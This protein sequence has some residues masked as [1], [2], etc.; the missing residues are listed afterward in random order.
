MKD[1]LFFV[2]HCTK[3]FRLKLVLLFIAIGCSSS[4]GMVY[5]Y[6]LSLVIDNIFY[7][8]NFSFIYRVTSIYIGLF[9]VTQVIYAIQHFVW[10]NLM[11]AFLLSVRRLVF[12]RILALKAS[13]LTSFETGDLVF[14]IN[15]D[16]DQIM[17]FIFTNGF[18]FIA[19]LLRVIASVICIA[20]LSNEMAVL[21]L[22][23]APFSAYM[24]F[25]FSEKARMR[26]KSY[27]E[28]YNRVLSWVSEVIY[29]IKE[30]FHLSAS[31]KARVR[32]NEGIHS[33]GKDKFQISMLEVYS[34]RLIAFVNLLSTLLFY[35]G[36]VYLMS[37]DRLTLGALVAILDYYS[38][39]KSLLLTVNKSMMSLGVRIASI[40]RIVR[41]FQLETE[42]SS[43]VAPL[44]ITQGQIC[45]SNV[46]F[47][48]GNLNVVSEVDLLVEPGSKI[49]IVGAN[50]AGKSTLIDLLLRFYEPSN[51]E[52]TID[53]QNICNYSI[54]SLRD[55]IGIVQQFPVMFE[56]TIYHNL[57]VA[58]EGCSEEALISAAKRAKLWDLICS[59][60]LG[61]DTQLSI[62]EVELSGGE[63]QRFSIARMLL[64]NPKVIVFDEATS[65][66]DPETDEYIRDMLNVHFSDRTIITVAHRLASV[67]DADTIAVMDD[68][69][70]VAIGDHRGLLDSCSVYQE[71]FLDQT[72]IQ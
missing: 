72:S 6:L 59:F 46:S 33:L 13:Y 5:P 61:F 66:L 67:M 4:I 28:K 10:S 35:G 9:F 18:Y 7:R 58:R 29:G 30:I 8:Q 14:V 24:S 19:N 3:G 64:K 16:V 53:G 12:K 22:V 43:E 32:Y 56:G 54:D 21:A 27:L 41:L 69:K 25:R 11:T 15:R 68:G 70:V 57:R 36:A 63:K 39:C 44:I 48:Y 2:W 52:I 65:A 55:Q 51:G 1:S 47:S 38:K 20:I 17:E 49:A 34:D 40:D 50:G 71:L 26:Q 45:F 23:F 42:E 37:T 31:E 62:N 60:P